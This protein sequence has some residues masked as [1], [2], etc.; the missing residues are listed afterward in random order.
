LTSGVAYSAG[1]GCLIPPLWPA[2]LIV[3]WSR[4]NEERSMKRP[5]A[6]KV[7]LETELMDARGACGRI[8]TSLVDNQAT[9][10]LDESETL[11]KRLD[12]VRDLSDKL[13][14]DL[15]A[16][17][18]VH[19]CAVGCYEEIVKLLDEVAQKHTLLGKLFNTFPDPQYA[20]RDAVSARSQRLLGE[21][22]ARMAASMRLRLNDSR[23]V[24]APYRSFSRNVR[25]WFAFHLSQLVRLFTHRVRCQ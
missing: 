23:R 12:I 24:R 19:G 25:M 22:C 7:R 17:L 10:P 14:N 16:H 1:A 3:F 9:L 11:S 5:C 15:D 21:E 18:L 20:E 8:A 13:K 6:A 4:S 2:L